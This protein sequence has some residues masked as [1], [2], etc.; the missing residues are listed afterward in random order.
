MDLTPPL[1]ITPFVL[2]WDA[3]SVGMSDNTFLEDDFKI[4]L[5]DMFPPHT[6]GG[7]LF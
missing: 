1:K 2:S 4:C 7:N 3:S 6:P 5:K